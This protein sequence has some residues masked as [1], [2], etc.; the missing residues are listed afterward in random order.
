MSSNHILP[1][2]SV[3]HGPEEGQ[4]RRVCVR[5]ADFQPHSRFTELE[6]AFKQKHQVIRMHPG[7]EAQ[8]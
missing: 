3:V 1:T 2:Q 7:L 6:S 5:N 4:V 8:V